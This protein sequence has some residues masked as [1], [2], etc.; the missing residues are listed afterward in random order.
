MNI[1]M[2]IIAVRKHKENHIMGKLSMKQL[3]L[4][5]NLMY[6]T[7]TPPLQSIIGLEGGWTVGG[8]INNIAWRNQFQQAFQENKDYGSFIMGGDWEYILSAIYFEPQLMDVQL[9]GTYRDDNGG[10]ESALFFN[11][12]ANEA[13]VVFRGTAAG[14]WKDNFIGA[15]ATD[16]ADGVS[17]QYQIHALEWY[18]SL[19]L[20][21]FDSVTVSGHSK[22]GNKAKYITI[23][24]ASVDRCVSFDGQGFSDEF[25][26]R[27][28]SE[29]SV[30]QGKIENHNVDYDY[31]NLLLNDIG[32]SYFYVRQD[33]GKGGF[34]ENHAPNTFMKF[35]G[36]G[37]FTMEKGKRPSSIKALDEFLNS[38]LRAVS[39]EEKADKIKI[40]G[41]MADIF[42]NSPEHKKT[43]KLF[44]YLS[45]PEPAQEAVK[46]L[47]YFSKYMETC[48][49]KDEINDLLCQVGM[50]GI[51][52]LV[53]TAETVMKWKYF[54][55]VAVLV[56]FGLNHL[57]GWLEEKL[58][59]LLEHNLKINIGEEQFRWLLKIVLQIAIE[60]LN[61]ESAPNMGADIRIS[62]LSK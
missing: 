9:L 38:Y 48:D 42:F 15:G 52:N 45:T 4:L 55:E 11:P 34:A 12:A 47:A 49:C 1:I 30:R 16:A 43:E 44:Q 60:R 36:D 58:C 61:I 21:P 8:M 57:P 2:H 7:D 28:Q 14:E 51:I 59:Q 20:S 54:D 19:D 56:G 10:G 37:S 25:M 29:I 62:S 40:Y 33:L 18:Q 50:G 53:N 26:A 41:N 13:I 31:V 5:N 3:L 6:M 17:T 24:D 22:G 27:Y 32:N 35:H 23:L 39:P 46:L